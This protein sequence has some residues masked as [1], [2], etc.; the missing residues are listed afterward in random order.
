MTAA[1]VAWGGAMQLYSRRSE[2]PHA[3]Q[4]ASGRRWSRNA[5]FLRRSFLAPLPAQPQRLFAFP[6]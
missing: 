3:S 1:V 2:R 6:V 5:R 4:V